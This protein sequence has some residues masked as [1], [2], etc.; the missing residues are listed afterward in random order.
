MA[1]ESFW[2]NLGKSLFQLFLN[3][4]KEDSEKGKKKTLAPTEA[5]VSIPFD[6]A[7]Q[8]TPKE[9]TPEIGVRPFIDWACATSNITDHFL[10]GDCIALHAWNRLATE[11]DG[12]TEDGR[13]KLIVLCVKMEEI[14]A[15]LNCSINVHCMFRSQDYNAKV[16]KAIPNDVHAQMLAVDFDCNGHYTIDELHTKLEPELEKFGMR[17]ERNTPTWVHLDL[18]PVVNARY[19]NA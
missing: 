18:H 17:M 16:V 11:E 1:D 9:Q 6:G 10:V 2:L 3:K 8:E 7:A 5:T 19:F 13:Q 15:F 4:E 12:L 14:R